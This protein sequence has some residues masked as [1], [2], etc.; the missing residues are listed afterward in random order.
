MDDESM[1]STTPSSIDG[2]PTADL[3]DENTLFPGSNNGT[4]TGPVRP[5]TPQNDHLN[6]SAPGELSPPRSQT[7]ETRSSF[8]NGTYDAP[9]NAQ[10]TANM[11]NEKTIADQPGQGWKNKKAQEEMQRSWDSVVDKDLNLKEFGD[12]VMQGK[13]Q[14]GEA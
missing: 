11:G 6:A 12:V 5:Q 1:N 3:L 13:Q 8:T 10:P 4:S 7:Y 9:T 14:R 2:Q